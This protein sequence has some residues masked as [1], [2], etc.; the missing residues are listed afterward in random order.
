M[1]DCSIKIAVRVR[2]FNPREIEGNAQLVVKMNGA[3][4]TLLPPP[5]EGK[6]DRKYENKNFTF[7]YSYWTHDDFYTDP[8]GKTHPNPGSNFADQAKVMNDLGGTIMA[9]AWEGFNTTLLA[10]G[11]TGSGKSYSMF[12]YG[13]NKGIVPMFCEDLFK[14]IEEKK[15]NPKNG[16][17]IEYAVTFSML[18]IYQEKVNDLLGDATS[19]ENMKVRNHPK[20]GFYV[21]GLKA[22][23]VTKYPEIERLCER[24]TKNRTVAS[25][26]MNATSSRSHTIIVI[27]FAQINKADNTEKRSIINLVD[28]AGSERQGDTQA[29]GQ[30][31]K[32]GANINSSLTIGAIS[33][34]HDAYEDSLSTLRF[35]D[36][37]KGIK[38]VAAINENPIDKCKELK[39]ENE[40]LKQKL[41]AGGGGTI[42]GSEVLAEGKILT[43]EQIAE[44]AEIRR[45]IIEQEKAMNEMN[46]S[47]ALKLEEAMLQKSLQDKES[48]EEKVTAEKKKTNPYLVNVNEDPFLSGLM[49]HFIEEGE[50]LIGRKAD[51]SKAEIQLSGLSILSS[52][53][54]VSYNKL[55]KQVTIRPIGNAN[56]RVNG[57]IVI[58]RPE[59]ETDPTVTN[60][61]ILNHNDR[62][63]F[64]LQHLFV[65]KMPGEV[66]PPDFTPISWR[67]AQ[68]EVAAAEGYGTGD[69]GLSNTLINDITELLPAVQEAN[70]IA[71]ELFFPKRYVLIINKQDDA[72]SDIRGLVS[73]KVKD[74]E[75]H[76]KWI[77]SKKRFLESRL[78][79]NDMYAAYISGGGMRAINDWPKEKN[80][81]EVS[82]EDWLIGSS[83]VTFKNILS[84]MGVRESVFVQNFKGANEGI[85][86]VTVEIIANG[87]D[88]LLAASVSGSIGDL[89]AGKSKGAV[90][91]KYELSGISRDGFQGEF[92]H[93][94]KSF[95]GSNP[96]FNDV[97]VLENGSVASAFVRTLSEMELLIDLYG[98]YD[99]KSI[100]NIYGRPKTSATI[101]EHT[102]SPETA[103]ERRASYSGHSGLHSP[104]S[105]E[106]L[107]KKKQEK[108]EEIKAFLEILD[109]D[110]NAD[111]LLIKAKIAEL[112]AK[113][114][115]QLLITPGLM[116]TENIPEQ[117]NESSQS[118]E[119]DESALQFLQKVEEKLINVTTNKEVAKLKEDIQQELEKSEETETAPEIEQRVRNRRLWEGFII[120]FRDLKE[121]E[122]L[123]KKTI[124]DIVD[125]CSDAKELQNLKLGIDATNSIKIKKFDDSKSSDKMAMDLIDSLEERL[126]AAKRVTSDFKHWIDPTLKLTYLPFAKLQPEQQSLKKDC[127]LLVLKNYASV[128]DILKKSENILMGEISQCVQRGNHHFDENDK[129]LVRNREQ[130][131]L[132]QLNGK[133]VNL[134]IDAIGLAEG[135]MKEQSE[136]MDKLKTIVSQQAARGA[137]LENYSKIQ[138]R[139]LQYLKT[140]IAR[141][142]T[143]LESREKDHQEEN[144]S[145]GDQ[146]ISKSNQL[147][148]EF[149]KNATLRTEVKSLKDDLAKCQEKLAECERLKKILMTQNQ[150]EKV[151]ALMELHRDQTTEMEALKSKIKNLKEGSI[152]SEPKES[153]IPVDKKNE[154]QTKKVYPDHVTVSKKK[155]KKCIIM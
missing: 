150:D 129:E 27:S 78:L 19:G 92:V 127:A 8:D 128:V 119:A 3:M 109:S 117:I 151:K 65:I 98:E 9:N 107:E 144:K 89:L 102:M 125:K 34:A 61:T 29:E 93:K 10:Y 138:M 85:L 24:G 123:Y 2:P 22:V 4:T 35:L 79:M 105:L 45:Q 115:H 54:L 152:N 124:L 7:D 13:A 32:E 39:E 49:L 15:A 76:R 95:T 73:V 130:L 96:K 5:Q 88:D 112:I 135:K 137:Y 26:R 118:N 146:L 64:G 28:L 38:N 21:E 40:T 104:Q 52:H 90:Y 23:P 33:P 133:A 81:F 47:W 48:A 25:T 50:H 141:L 126:T 87:I 44:N 60:G 101:D 139:D 149:T 12:G 120:N 153:N 147:G 67:R 1:A 36:R 103:L 16:T 145:L 83:K 46:K 97:N 56:I 18:E 134:T 75:K 131:R 121:D 63:M 72:D 154:M 30:R 132:M 113:F 11:Q 106:R 77:Q 110:K 17:V 142:N 91:C 114:R 20:L 51:S 82:S 111:P 100:K 14:L 108:V 70:A 74:F 59:A 37:A 41:L 80:P 69:S 62:I 122:D 57:Q 58:L 53:G 43:P 31:L 86:N 42:D 55:T 136:R 71:E 94:T 6:T 148:Q 140:E 68:R 143:M 99:E 66:D 155:G 84:V 116:S